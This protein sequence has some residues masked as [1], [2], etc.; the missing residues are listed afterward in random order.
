MNIMDASHAR[1][2]LKAQRNAQSRSTDPVT[3]DESGIWHAWR[4]LARYIPRYSVLHRAH[5]YVL[6]LTAG[7][8]RVMPH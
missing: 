3:S 6:I 2:D 7:S 8:C 1:A 5:L 4:A